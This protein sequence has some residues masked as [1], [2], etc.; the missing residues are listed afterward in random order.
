M[1]KVDKEWAPAVALGVAALI[2]VG[3]VNEA[4]GGKLA[5]TYTRT[6]DAISPGA[7]VPVTPKD[8]QAAREAFPRLPVKPLG[9][10][11]TYDR[12]KFGTP[13]KDIAVPGVTPANNCDTR[14][15]ILRRDLTAVTPPTGCKVASGTLADPYTGKTIT[16]RAGPD[17]EKVQIDHVVALSAAWAQGAASWD[18]L[19]RT[20]FANDPRNLLAVDGPTNQKKSDDTAE[21]WF[22]PV[23]FQCAFTV[24][25]VTVKAAYE[26]SVSEEERD[27][28]DRMLKRCP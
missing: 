27:A 14:S 23:A 7:P 22:P 10:R 8:V 26:L 21:D 11:T 18:T 16:Y 15:D 24:R 6:Q 13:W 12:T 25:V 1:S 4:T 9:T 3:L 20:R 19:K 17:A 28:L 5:D 2:A